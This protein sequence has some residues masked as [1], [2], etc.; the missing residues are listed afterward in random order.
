[1][2]FITYAIVLATMAAMPFNGC[3][4]TPIQV[5]DNTNVV[6]NTVPLKS[7]ND[8][9]YVWESWMFSTNEVKSIDR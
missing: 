5:I 3:K 8:E 2:K 6:T 9:S 1:M 7:F 4:S